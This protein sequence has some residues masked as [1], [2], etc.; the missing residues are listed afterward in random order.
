MRKALLL[1]GGLLAALLT[2]TPPAKADLQNQMNMMFNGL[3]NVTPPTVF[4]TQRRGGI[5]GGSVNLRNRIM[6][7]QLVSVVPPSFQAGCGGID[8]FMGS[9]SFISADQFVHLLR[10]VAANASGYAFNMA[11]GAI[12]PSCQQTMET[13][14]KKIQALNQLGANSCQ[15]AKG[16]VTD[17]RSAVEEGKVKEGGLIAQTTGAAQGVFNAFFDNTK[18]PQEKAKEGNPDEFRRKL[19]GN[20]MWRALVQSGTAGWFPGG[21][22][23]L[24][25]VIMNITGTVI[26]QDELAAA[27][28]GKG[29]TF[30]TVEFPG[31][32]VT[33]RDLVK[34]GTIKIYHCDTKSED[35]CLNPTGPTPVTITGF[36]SM[37][38]E[39][40]IGGANS[41]GVLYKVNRQDGGA[42]TEQENRILGLSPLGGA[43]IRLNALSPGSSE[44]VANSVAPHIAAHLAISIIDELLRSAE[45]ASVVVNHPDMKSQ[46]DRIRT[47]RTNMM[48]EYSQFQA[49]IGSEAEQFRSY[50][51][52]LQVLP[53]NFYASTLR[54]GR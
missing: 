22:D 18:S 10:A 11:L 1:A 5:A 7:E 26:V 34:G 32:R 2:G 33:I 3:S 21:N 16:L 27:P 28:D 20:L 50:Q 14:Q 24:N 30:K 44:T 38:R 37:V 54:P 8:M 13:L 15:L 17:L 52:V 25:E 4:E 29:K 6:N 9:F 45:A 51:A 42:P 41:K 47:A 35:G 40:L 39:A 31:S 46:T 12:C 19:A 43:L 53:K 36:E 49:E 23:S 48:A